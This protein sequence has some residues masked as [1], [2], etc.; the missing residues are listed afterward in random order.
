[1]RVLDD[2]AAQTIGEQEWQILRLEAEN[3]QLRDEV[4]TLRGRNADV[5]GPLQSATTGHRDRRTQA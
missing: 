3:R 2:L 4:Q 1:M 5:T